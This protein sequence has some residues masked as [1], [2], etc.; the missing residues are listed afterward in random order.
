[1]F[2]K[3]LLS[4]QLHQLVAWVSCYVAP[5]SC[6]KLK[7]CPAAPGWYTHRVH[8]RFL[9]DSDGVLDSQRSAGVRGPLSWW[10]CSLEAALR[11]ATS[12]SS[13]SFTRRRPDYN[14]FFEAG[15][16]K[17]MIVVKVDHLNHK[18]RSVVWVRVRRQSE[19]EKVKAFIQRQRK[20]TFSHL[21]QLRKLSPAECRHKGTSYFQNDKVEYM[22]PWTLTFYFDIAICKMAT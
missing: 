11:R 18:K 17:I 5:C 22:Q 12:G 15:E 21:Y 20:S 3:I 4:L 1:M 8:A 9:F 7:S 16:E 10:W 13:R 14:D 2:V 6:C 19:M